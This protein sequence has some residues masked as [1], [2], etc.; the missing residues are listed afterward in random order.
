M[1]NRKEWNVIQNTLNF[2]NFYQSEPDIE[3]MELPQW[4]FTANSQFDLDFVTISEIS[5]KPKVV[6]KIDP[7]ET[8]RGFDV[9]LVAFSVSLN[10]EC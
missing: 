3:N 5:F 2:M 9:E 1:G 10:T 4:Q 6:D 8:N 7:I